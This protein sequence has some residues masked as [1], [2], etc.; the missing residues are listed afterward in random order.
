[1]LGLAKSTA[2]LLAKSNVTCNAVCPSLVRTKLLDNDY[3][4]KAML[5][6]NPIWEAFNERAKH[7]HVLPVGAYDPEQISFS[8]RRAAKNPDFGMCRALVFLSRRIASPYHSI[9]AQQ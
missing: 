7:I 6:K 2:R 3:I 4:L 5:L 1:V 9:V 8:M